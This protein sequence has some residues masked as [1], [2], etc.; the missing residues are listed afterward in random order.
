MLKK[1]NGFTLIELAV[2]IVI[3]SVLAAFAV[4]RFRDAVERSKATEAFN[5]LAAVR[6]SQERYHARLGTYSDDMA[7]LDIKLS[8]PKY[9]TVGS[10]QAGSTGSLKA[11]WSQALTRTGASA[12]YGQYIVTYTEDGYDETNST[13][14]KAPTINPMRI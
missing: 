14:S 7:K 2:V 10:I 1:S 13:I 3:V 4:P 6:V 9:F 5:Y 8:T 11:S 12:G